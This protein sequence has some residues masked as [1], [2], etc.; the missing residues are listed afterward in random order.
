MWLL[1][2]RH[3]FYFPFRTALSP[4]DAQRLAAWRSGGERKSSH[5]R[6][7]FK[8]PQNFPRAYTPPDAKPFVGGSFIPRL[9][10]L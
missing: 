7:T 3:Q 1:L 6:Q 10:S 8:F 2:F 9:I 4:A 5:G